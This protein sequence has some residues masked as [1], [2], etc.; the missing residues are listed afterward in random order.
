MTVKIWQQSGD[1][2]EVTSM[3]MEWLY[4]KKKHKKKMQLCVISIWVHF[5]SEMGNFGIWER[6]LLLCPIL[7]DLVTKT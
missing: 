4:W 3:I 1:E 6:A 5:K 2:E 7:Q